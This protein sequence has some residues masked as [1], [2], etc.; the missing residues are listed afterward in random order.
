MFYRKPS[1]KR[2][3]RG[4]RMTDYRC[5]LFRTLRNLRKLVRPPPRMGRLSDVSSCTTLKLVYCNSFNVLSGLPPEALSSGSAEKLCKVTGFF[6]NLQIFSEFF[7]K[8][9]FAASGGRYRGNG[10]PARPGALPGGPGR[11]PPPFLPESDREA[12]SFSRTSKTFPRKIPEFN[13]I[14]RK[15]PPN[16]PEK[17]GKGPAKG[18]RREWKE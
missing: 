15:S 7:F 3:L 8:T 5:F 13:I 11:P 2:L 6:R 12:T 10:S 14:L 1:G 9:F 16:R 4:R 18:R 17:P